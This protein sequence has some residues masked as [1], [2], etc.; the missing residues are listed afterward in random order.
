MRKKAGSVV[1]VDRSAT[2]SG[3]FVSESMSHASPTSWI[4][5]PRYEKSD[6]IQ[7]ARKA[8]MARGDDEA[9]RAGG[10]TEAP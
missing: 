2:G 10:K 8:G 9:M 7:R 6:A 1:Q 4:H 5:V 3:L